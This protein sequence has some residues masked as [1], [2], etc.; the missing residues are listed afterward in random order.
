MKVAQSAMAAEQRREAP[1]A[2]AQQLQNSIYAAEAIEKEQ[3]ALTEI[4][5]EFKK[6]NELV[7]GLHSKFVKDHTINL[8]EAKKV[9]GGLHRLCFL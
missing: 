3:E 8:E 6:A 5:K 1:P 4:R 7:N 2:A 9:D